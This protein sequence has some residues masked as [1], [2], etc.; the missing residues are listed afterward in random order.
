MKFNDITDENLKKWYNF[1]G[2]NYT[3]QFLSGKWQIG[4]IMLLANEKLSY[5][6]LV[7]KLP[8]ITESVLSRKLKQLEQQGIIKKKIYPEIPP[9]TEYSL[10]EMGKELSHIVDLM[11]KFGLKYSKR[12]QNIKKH[13]K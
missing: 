5:S 11:Q 1:V 12:L 2:A 4:I 8:F 6:K 3:N 7:Q 13:N 9:H 10:T